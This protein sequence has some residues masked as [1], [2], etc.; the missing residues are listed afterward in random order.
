MNHPPLPAHP[1]TRRILAW[2]QCCDIEALRRWMKQTERALRQDFDF[3]PSAS[4]QQLVATGLRQTYKR[5]WDEGLACWVILGSRVNP[6]AVNLLA[7]QS[8]DD[9]R[10]SALRLL[11]ARSD[12]ATQG[13]V[14]AKSHAE[15]RSTLYQELWK[16]AGLAVRSQVVKLVIENP[17]IPDL[18][19]SCWTEAPHPGTHV[20]YELIQGARWSDLNRLYRQLPPVQQARVVEVSASAGHILAAATQQSLQSALGEGQGHAREEVAVFRPRV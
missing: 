16:E 12:V 20:A 3:R 14:L 5:E 11:N 18:P 4:W 7:L 10:T 13:Q 19:A 17:G 8:F 9:G 2:N 1:D 15:G 6:E